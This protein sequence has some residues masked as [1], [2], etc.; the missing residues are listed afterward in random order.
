MT[1]STFK[2]YALGQLLFFCLAWTSQSCTVKNAL[3]SSSTEASPQGSDTKATPNKKATYPI[4][5]YTKDNNLGG[6]AQAVFAGGCFWCTEAAFER[7]GGV[8][9]VVSGYSGGEETYPT[10]GEVGAGRTG[11]TEAIYI[12]Y[13]A[14]KISYETLLDVLFVA[15]DPTTLNRQGPD[16]GAQYRSA[17]FF[18][19]ET[20]K[21][22][23]DSK[24]KALN[25]GET[26]PGK[27]VTQVAPYEEFWLAEEYHQN[28]YEL[29]PNQ[30][31]VRSVS[32]PKVNKVIKA[33]PELI[34]VTYR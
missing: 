19:N 21:A 11:H 15:H 23:I 30:S 1:I 13:D 18:Q 10:Y 31:Y 3:P 22:T 16:K 27:I 2:T 29:N 14:D 26:L 12:Y 5:Q 4:A 9:D 25:A 7:I 8:V 20:E 6:Y 33:F 28:F 34:K 24:I 32:R 17:I